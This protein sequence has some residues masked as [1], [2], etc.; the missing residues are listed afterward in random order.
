MASRVRFR[1]L[2][3]ALCLFLSLCGFLSPSFLTY[4]SFCPSV[5]LSS[6]LLSSLFCLLSSVSGCLFCPCPCFPPPFFP[7]LLL[8]F[9]SLCLAT[10]VKTGWLCGEVLEVKCAGK[11][12]WWLCFPVGPP[13]T[14]QQCGRYTE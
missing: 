14:S 13:H 4:F 2:S 9:R 1:C 7:L 3:L 10:P 11:E 12:W 8:L 6:V 5:C